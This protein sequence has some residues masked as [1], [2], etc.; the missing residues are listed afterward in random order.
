MFS[1][2]FTFGCLDQNIPIHWTSGLRLLPVKF[3]NHGKQIAH[4][5]D[6]ARFADHV[7]CTHQQLVQMPVFDQVCM[8]DWVLENR[9]DFPSQLEVIETQMGA[10]MLHSDPGQVVKLPK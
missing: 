4:F 1:L 9:P 6:V 10:K 3:H 2:P 7:Y 5:G 8:S